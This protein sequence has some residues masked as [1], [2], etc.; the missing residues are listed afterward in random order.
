MGGK[1][2]WAKGEGKQKENS[3]EL[4]HGTCHFCTRYTCVSKN[5]QCVQKS[6]R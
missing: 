4:M 1:E 3:D 2:K 6:K 5:Q